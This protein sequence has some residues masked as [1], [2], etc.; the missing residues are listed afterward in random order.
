MSDNPANTGTNADLQRLEEK[1]EKQGGIIS[2]FF[3]KV[4]DTE[5]KPP[6]SEPPSSTTDSELLKTNLE[7]Q[8]KVNELELVKQH[9]ELEQ[10]KSEEAKKALE[11]KYLNEKIDKEIEALVD[12]RVIAAGDDKEKAN[13]KKL[14]NADYDAIKSIAESRIKSVKEEDITQ[15]STKPTTTQQAKEV[16]AAR[17]AANFLNS[18]SWYMQ[19]VN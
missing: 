9:Y 11:A 12:A 2:K 15:P 10:Q 3:G 17:A 8:K 5:E 16:L 4:F 13:W 19:A 18:G 7:L 14:F 6:A 1:I